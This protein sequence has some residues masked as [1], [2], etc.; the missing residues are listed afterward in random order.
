MVKRLHQA[1]LKFDLFL[2]PKNHTK[3]GYNVGLAIETPNP[4]TTHIFYT[5]LF[6]AFSLLSTVDSH[7]N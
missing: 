3:L 2:H 4:M 1:V 7:I 6:S 5:I